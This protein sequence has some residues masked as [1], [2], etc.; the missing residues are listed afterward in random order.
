M[1]ENERKAE[2]AAC[3]QHYESEID[4]GVILG[5]WEESELHS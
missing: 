4:K 3:D 1:L 2:W 5:I